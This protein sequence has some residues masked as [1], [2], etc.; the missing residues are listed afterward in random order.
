ML[1]SGTS[2]Q[3]SPGEGHPVGNWWPELSFQDVFPCYIN[4]L[5]TSYGRGQEKA[6]HGRTANNERKVQDS[7]VAPGSK[8]YSV[9]SIIV[10][11]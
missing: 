2:C 4:I 11:H 9:I 8:C 1:L 5:K 6:S 3:P 7:D 10:P